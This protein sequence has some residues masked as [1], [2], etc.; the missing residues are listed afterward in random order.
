MRLVEIRYT[1][2]LPSGFT[3][4]EQRRIWSF[5][6]FLFVFFLQKKSKKYTKNYNAL[7][8]PLFCSLNL[9]FGDVLVAV[10]VVFCLRSLMYYLQHDND[11]I[12]LETCKPFFVK[13]KNIRYE[14][15][16]KLGFSLR[17]LRCGCVP[18]TFSRVISRVLTEPEYWLLA[19]S[20]QTLLNQ[21][22]LFTSGDF[23]LLRK[24]SCITPLS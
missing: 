4:Y 9:F 7:V 24:A 15:P 10:V 16:L 2:N 8:Q 22:V 14:Y 1:K 12:Y 23:I 19:V 17:I 13:K 18:G 6:L 5:H 21:S 3:F 20:A 11:L